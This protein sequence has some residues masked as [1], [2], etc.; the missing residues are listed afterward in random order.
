MI[1]K[2]W[3]TYECIDFVPLTLSMSI[4]DPKTL[5]SMGDSSGPWGRSCAALIAVKCSSDNFTSVNLNYI[6]SVQESK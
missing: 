1:P 6:Y 2:Y 5:V 4:G 3:K